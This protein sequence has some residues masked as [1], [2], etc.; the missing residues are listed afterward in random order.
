MMRNGFH[1]GVAKILHAAFRARRCGCFRRSSA[2]WFLDHIVRS[3]F[4]PHLTAKTNQPKPY[5][6]LL[7]R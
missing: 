1:T 3:A 5:G 6:T 7:R 4:T 2:P